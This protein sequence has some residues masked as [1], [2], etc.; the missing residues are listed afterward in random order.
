MKCECIYC[1]YNKENRCILE[2]TQIDWFGMCTQCETVAVPL[3]Y[4]EQ[5]KEK[6]LRELRIIY[7]R[8]S[9]CDESLG[10]GEGDMRKA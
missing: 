7:D 5:C 1:V 3:T 10:R 8:W 6:R 2:K 4:I 9:A